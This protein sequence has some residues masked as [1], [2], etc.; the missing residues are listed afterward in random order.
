MTVHVKDLI[1]EAK[2]LYDQAIRI[3]EEGSDPEAALKARQMMDDADKLKEQAAETES[4]LAE[5][6]NKAGEVNSLSGRQVPGSAKF[7]DL[8]EFTFKVW[9]ACNPRLHKVDPRLKFFSDEGPEDRKEMAEGTG[10]AGGYLV[11]VDQRMQL[12]AISGEDAIV[13]PRA[14]VIRA[15]RR[16]VTMPVLDQTGTTAGSPH[17]F[18]GMSFRWED[19]ATQHNES[20]PSFRYVTLTVKKLV[21]YTRA[22][23][24]LVD[25]AG[26]SLMD[27]FSSPLGFA[28]GV[29]WMEDDAFLNGTGAG[30]PLGVLDT[31][32]GATKSIARQSK[33]GLVSYQDFARMRAGFVATGGNGVWV[34]NQSLMD[35]VIQLSGPSGNASYIWAPNAANGIPGTL[36]GLPVIWSEK[37][38]AAGSRGDVLLA[39]FNYYLVV[40]RQATTI[41]STVYDQWAYDKTSWKVVHRVDG[42][43]W[44]STVLTLKDGTSTISPFVVLGTKST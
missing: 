21:G 14:T 38:P 33:T 26:I 44:L 16:Q 4:L 34:I 11:P 37:N 42:Q 18:G 7:R 12:M 25:D 9:E 29:A 13:R 17:W 20:S 39:N 1:G 40:D 23:N 19:E 8:G 22:P 36:L 32:C 31:A 15:T 2:A 5:A 35:E 28:G 10:A 3:M 41:E 30:Q 27:F 24:E 6:K 43:P